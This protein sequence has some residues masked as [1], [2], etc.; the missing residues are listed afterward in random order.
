MIRIIL[1]LLISAAI[2][3]ATN[4]LAVKMLFRP[5]KP[6]YIGK[7]RLP[8]TPGIIPK[9]KPRLAKALSAAVSDSLLTGDDIEDAVLSNKAKMLCAEKLCIGLYMRER[10]KLGQMLNDLSQGCTYSTARKKIKERIVEKGTQA[11]VDIDIAQI[12]I[13]EIVSAVRE[14]TQGTMAAMFINDD[15]IAEL[16]KP[17][18]EKFNEYIRENAPSAIEKAVEEEL[19]AAES[20][21][22]PQVFTELNITQ[23]KLT[24]IIGIAMESLLR[25]K[26]SGFL[27]ELDVGS[28]VEKHINDM[29]NKELEELI[30]SVM[31]KELNAVVNLGALIGLI[32]GILNVLV[33][34]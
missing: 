11:A 31:K 16:T 33:N 29:D 19:I 17:A 32:I 3:Y 13:G 14:K 5:L 30:L 10:N 7:K 4:Y 27:K 18:A 21:T 24:R 6:I 1:T 12:M 2:G 25:G 28:A 34:M 15:L 8:F 22:V 9:G 26:L 20:M 23:E